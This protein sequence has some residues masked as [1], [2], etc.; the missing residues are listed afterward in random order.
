MFRKF[1]KKMVSK[2]IN[3]FGPRSITSSLLP[4]IGHLHLISTTWDDGLIAEA[5]RKE[6]KKAFGIWSIRVRLP[7]MPRLA[8]SHHQVSFAFGAKVY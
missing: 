3:S 8:H 1:F 6:C 7:E 4:L 5:T 2:L